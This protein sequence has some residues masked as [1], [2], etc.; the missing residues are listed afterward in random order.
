MQCLPPDRLI[1]YQ[2]LD[3]MHDCLAHSVQCASLACTEYAAHRLTCL[4]TAGDL[5][6]DLA[7]EEALQ[8]RCRAAGGSLCERV[9]QRLRALPQDLAPADCRVLLARARRRFSTLA[10]VSSLL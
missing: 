10:L 3:A 2:D 7:A 4:A 1:G 9:A 5:H 8:Q 6:Q